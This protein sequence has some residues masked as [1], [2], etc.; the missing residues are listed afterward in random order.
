MR[1]PICAVCHKRFSEGGGLLSFT[2]TDEEK[3]EKKRFDQPGFVGHPPGL[4]WFCI[5]NA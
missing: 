4:E 5:C 1:P 3:E 2:L